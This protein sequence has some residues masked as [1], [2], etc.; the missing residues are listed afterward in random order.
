MTYLLLRHFNNNVVEA[1]DDSGD[2]CVLTG[3]GIGFG[4]VKG[5]EIPEAKIDV[6][7]IPENTRDVDRV[8]EKISNIPPEIL[9]VVR[10]ASIAGEQSLNM[11]PSLAFELSLADHLAGALRRYQTNSMVDF[12]LYYEMT[13]LYPAELAFGRDVLRLIHLKL[14]VKLP[15]DE[16]GAI[17]LHAVAHLM[18]DGQ[19]GVGEAMAFT[20]VMKVALDEIRKATGRDIALGD[21]AVARFVTHMRYLFG[22]LR[23]S[24]KIQSE[25][26]EIV[27]AIEQSLER[28]WAI[29]GT[30]VD[31]VH[32]YTGMTLGKSERAYIALHIGRL[33]H[34]D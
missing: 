13:Q 28:S 33:L 24:K 15:D 21:S 20:Q 14:G 6:R 7:Y 10:Q 18:D 29:A 12:P 30:V 19:A 1:E 22:R 17:A 26:D 3:K 25:P 11:A 32:D 9:H 27:N 16:A 23:S 2:R 8:V 34:G 4:L 5:D 31:T